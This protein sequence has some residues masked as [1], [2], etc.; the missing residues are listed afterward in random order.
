[1]EGGGNRECRVREAGSSDPPVPPPATSLLKL[2]NSTS[3]ASDFTILYY[4]EDVLSSVIILK[5]YYS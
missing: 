1:M 3:P 4:R 5:M 2:E